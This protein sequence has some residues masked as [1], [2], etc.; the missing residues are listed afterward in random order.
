MKKATVAICPVPKSRDDAESVMQTLAESTHK[1]DS[2]MSAMEL[3]FI[4]IRQQYSV[5]MVALTEE[6]MRQKKALKKWAKKDQ[7]H[8]GDSKTL[9]L[10]HGTLAFRTTPK[11]LIPIGEMTM[12]TV[13]DNL[14]TL[15]LLDY[16]RTKR[17]P[18][19]EKILADAETLGEQ[20]E[21]IGLQVTQ[22]ET[23]MA[24]PKEEAKAT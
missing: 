17:E 24:T 12:D 16:V 22:R 23:F 1:L 10:M 21:V 18:N 8:W 19:L 6:I 13:L 11:A 20:L 9:E 5:E 7:E 2:V 15:H 3:E 14:I 4:P